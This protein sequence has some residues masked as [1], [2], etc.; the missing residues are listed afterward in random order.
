MGV[1]WSHSTGVFL[2]DLV[3]LVL[4]LAGAAK[5][6]VP[7]APLRNNFT[8]WGVLPWIRV[9]GAGALVSGILLA[10]P[11]TSFLG[12]L[13][14]GGYWG[15]ALLIHLSHIESLA[16]PSVLLLLLWIGAL[17]RFTLLPG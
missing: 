5:V 4:V 2:Q 12:T 10:V 14:A 16:A 17:M 7:P 1:L 6:A 11:A 8:R 9:V 15:G 13:V 3:A